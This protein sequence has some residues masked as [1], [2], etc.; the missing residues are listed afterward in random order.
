MHSSIGSPVKKAV[1]AAL[2]PALLA[3]VPVASAQPAATLAK[4]ISVV[5]SGELNR[6]VAVRAAPRLVCNSSPGGG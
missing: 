5:G 1:L 6:D 3:F 4:S 2:L